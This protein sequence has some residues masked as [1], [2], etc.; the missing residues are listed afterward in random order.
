MLDGVGR[1]VLDIIDDS[2][3]TKIFEF[4]KDYCLPSWVDEFYN[5]AVDRTVY[6]DGAPEPG[7]VGVG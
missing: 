3:T 2:G 1:K 7:W 4:S 6:D 5:S